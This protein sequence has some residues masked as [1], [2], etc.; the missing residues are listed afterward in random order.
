MLKSG[1]LAEFKNFN[2]KLKYIA[3]QINK[4]G[5]KKFLQEGNAVISFHPDK[6]GKLVPFL[7][8]PIP[9]E[10]RFSQ[11]KEALLESGLTGLFEQKIAGRRLIGLPY[12]LNDR[13]DTVFVSLNSGLM[14]CSTSHKMIM[15]AVFKNSEDDIRNQPG[16]S[17]IMLSA[18]ENE[19]KI[20][21]VFSNLRNTLKK[22][23][24][25]G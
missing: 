14:I 9:G 17:R 16:F 25:P 20:F 21:I 3:D 13:K 15:D 24:C 18:G 6:N 11:L 5:Y 23:A 19:D 1:N 12:T 8:K 2:I 7:S 10:T 22:N 4:P